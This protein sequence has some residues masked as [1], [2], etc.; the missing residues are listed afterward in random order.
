M[1]RASLRLRLVLAGGMSILAALVLSAVGLPLL[2]ERH[3]ERRVEGELGVLL[4]QIIAGIDRDSSGALILPKAPADPRFAQPLS[5][6][7]WQIQANDAVLRSR[8]LWDAELVLPAKALPNG[9]VRQLRVKGPGGSRLLASERSVTLPTRLGGGQMRAIVALDAADVVVATRAF[10]ADLFPYLAV[11][12]IVLMAA[13]YAQ[14]VVGLRPLGTVRA[15]LAAIGQGTTR[16]LGD[17]FPNE[18][19]PLAA[20]VDA[21]LDARDGQVDR[22]RA[23]AGDLAHGLKTPLQVLCGDIQRLREKGEDEIA[24]EIEKIAAT[25]RRHV[26]RELARVRSAAG[27]SDARASIAEVVDRV[28]AVMFRTPNGG[29]LEWAIDVPATLVA[30]IDADDLAEAIGNLVENAARHACKKVSIRTYS[31]GEFVIISVADDGAGIPEE[32]IEEAQARGHQLDRQDSGAG[33]GLA[34]VHDIASGWGGRFE[35]RNSPAGF[36]ANFAVRP[37]VAGDRPTSP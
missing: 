31:D 28:V 37:G 29:A 6:L 5:G 26:D 14:V 21:L 20:E 15:R 35:I 33:L 13:G 25:M 17:A 36:E 22:A 18:I 23:R 11:I 1:N 4:T 27:A 8:S 34:I 12:A 24:T 19:R 2:F 3:V 7:Y 9:A 32:Q 30:C 16:R 10:A